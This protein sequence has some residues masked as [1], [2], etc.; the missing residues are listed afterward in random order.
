MAMHIFLGISGNFGILFLIWQVFY[1]SAFTYH[2]TVSL[3]LYSDAQP[4][5]DSQVNIE[6]TDQP[7]YNIPSKYYFI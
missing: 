1:F 3:C 2:F 6:T 4:L 5:G 7:L